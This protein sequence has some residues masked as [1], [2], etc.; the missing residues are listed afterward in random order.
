MSNENFVNDYMYEMKLDE[1]SGFLNQDPQNL[2]SIK[3][4]PIEDEG[5][6]KNRYVYPGE[7]EE[8]YH[9]L[10]TFTKLQQGY[11]SR[12]KATL[13]E[14]SDGTRFVFVEHETGPEIIFVLDVI[15]NICMTIITAAVAVNQLLKLI[16]TICHVI[17]KE[18]NSKNKGEES[19]R[20]YGAKAISIEKRLSEGAK[21][22]RQVK[23]TANAGDKFIDSVHELLDWLLLARIKHQY[24]FKKLWTA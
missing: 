18:A 5:Q 2:I 16:N 22:I 23:I 11:V 6:W 1:A 24:K 20:Y 17:R 12:G 10:S 9:V 4:R 8:I 14:S 15:K 13:Y 3:I 21:M 19:C 7:Y